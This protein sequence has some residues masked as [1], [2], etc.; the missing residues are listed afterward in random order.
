[1]LEW[2]ALGKTHP[3]Y[4]GW[5]FP[6]QKRWARGE[7]PAR[8][9]RPQHGEGWSLLQAPFFLPFPLV[10]RQKGGG[11]YDGIPRM[12][13]VGEFWIC[14]CSDPIEQFFTYS[15]DDQ[16]AVLLPHSTLL[17]EV[18]MLC[19]EDGDVRSALQQRPWELG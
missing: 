3:H 16:R 10:R 19:K 11:S 6:Q 9:F 18:S 5:L 8:A 14:P 4:M 2:F 13:G 17:P 15:F 7:A 1:M 12:P